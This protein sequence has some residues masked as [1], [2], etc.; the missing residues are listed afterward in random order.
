MHRADH[1]ESH[2]GLRIDLPGGGGQRTEDRHGEFEHHAATQHREQWCKRAQRQTLDP[3]GEQAPRAVEQRHDH[4]QRTQRDQHAQGDLG[5]HQQPHGSEHEQ[6]RAE[7]HHPG[8][9]KGRDILRTRAGFLHRQEHDIDLLREEIGGRAP[10][11]AENPGKVIGSG[12]REVPHH[13][14]ICEPAGGEGQ[15]QPQR[16]HARDEAAHA[17]IGASGQQREREQHD[18]QRQDEREHRAE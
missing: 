6:Q 1:E 17:D 2:S 15:H 12:N 9:R 8:R 10:C 13:A 4:E 14:L 16:H 7:P 18:E 11:P 3:P 5:G